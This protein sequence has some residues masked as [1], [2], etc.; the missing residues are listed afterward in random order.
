MTTEYNLPPG[1]RRRS[2]QIL[3]GQPHYERVVPDRGTGRDR[4]KPVSFDWEEAKARRWDYFHPELGWLI[5]G[6][7]REK[8]P[9]IEEIMADASTTV[10]EPLPQVSGD[11]SGFEPDP[12]SN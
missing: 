6:F 4:I 2:G 7:K 3:R 9:S 12:I 1:V 11:G 8:D 10:A 5:D